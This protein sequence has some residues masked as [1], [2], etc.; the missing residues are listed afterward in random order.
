MSQ[1]TV[2]AK[3]KAKGGAEDNLHEECRKLVAPTLGA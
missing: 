2:I 3:L 1:L